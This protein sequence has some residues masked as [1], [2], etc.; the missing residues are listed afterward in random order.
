M[1]IGLV[2]PRF[3]RSAVE[4]NLLKRRLRELSRLRLLPSDVAADVVLRIRPEAYRASFDAL[5]ADV[6]RALGQLLRWRPTVAEP[7]AP[8]PAPAA[9]EPEERERDT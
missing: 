2:V 3:K 9:R 5:T 6:E 8:A 7:A 4:R 1:R